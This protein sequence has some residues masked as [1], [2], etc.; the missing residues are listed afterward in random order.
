MSPAGQ[1]SFEDLPLDQIEVSQ[2]NVRHT[3][4]E[5]GLEELA[6]SIKEIGLQQPVVVMR[7]EDPRKYEL[8]IGQRRYLASRKA[9]LPTILAIILP[10]KDRKDAAIAS[11][12]ENIHRHELEY[13]DKMQATM[14]LLKEFETVD[15][16]AKKLGVTAQTVRNYMGYRAVPEGIKKMVDDNRLAATTALRIAQGIPDEDHALRIAEKVQEL[17]RGVDRNRFIDL[18]REHPEQEPRG[19]VEMV[20]REKRR[21]RPLTIDL[22]PR[23]GE[24][25]EKACIDLGSTREDI[26]SDALEEWLA[27]RGFVE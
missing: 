6:E 12:S 23:I 9:A 16:V 19:V 7:T 21:F 1:V 5:K 25:L 18:A 17:P 13:R 8:I 27:R 26:A 4:V 3:N 10:P 2:H 24:A 15:E 14:E 11:F 20:E 22:T